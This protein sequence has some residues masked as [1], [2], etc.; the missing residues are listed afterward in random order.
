MASSYDRAPRAGLL[1]GFFSGG[2][3]CDEAMVIAAERLGPIASNIP[4]EP[5]W[6]LGDDL[7]SPGHLMIDFGD[8]QLTRGRP[9]PMIDPSLRI[10]RI[11]EAAADPACAV[12]LLD[13]VLGYGAHPDPAR[14]LAP[15]I[16]QARDRASRDGRDLAVVVSLIGSAG[17]PQGRDAVAG[18]LAARR[19]QRAP[20]QC[21]RGQHRGGPYQGSRPVIELELDEPPVVVTAGR[22]AVRRRPQGAGRR[23]ARGAVGPAGTRDRSQ[24]GRHRGR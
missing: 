8:D 22:V 21:R 5:D 15:A 20:V 9:H 4:L 14:S 6:A 13:V 24:P 17:D 10:E 7:R 3:L 19:S 16:A 23:A 12:L 11:A 2:T 18:A 1:R